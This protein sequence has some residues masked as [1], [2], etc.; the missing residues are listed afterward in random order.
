MVHPIM[1]LNFSYNQQQQMSML[2]GSHL[3][4]K[5]LNVNLAAYYHF[6]VYIISLYSNLYLAR[7]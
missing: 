2:F 6:F 4:T 7:Q 3:S 1:S 5:Y